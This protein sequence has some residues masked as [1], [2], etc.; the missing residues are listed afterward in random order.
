MLTQTKK[1]S[2]GKLEAKYP[3]V[4]K[5][6]RSRIEKGLLSG[7][8][9]GVREMADEYGVNFMTVNKAIKKLEA[10]GLVDCIP[11]K[12][13]YV[14]RQ[15]SVAAC[16]NSPTL[17]IL[18]IPV[19]HDVVMSAQ[20][21][22]RDHDCPMFLEG[23]SLEQQDVVDTLCQRIDG[24]LLF[25]SNMF[26]IHE[27]LLKMPY[28]RVMG[29]LGDK[30]PGDHVSYDNPMVGRIAADYLIGS[31]CRSMAYIGPF[32]QALFA[33][34]RD[35]F[36]ESIKHAGKKYYEFKTTWKYDFNSTLEQMELLMTLDKLPEAIFAPSDGIMSD[37]CSIL[38]RHGIQ[39]ET[40]IRLIG[41]NNDFTRIS[42]S[43]EIYASIDLHPKQIGTMAARQL[44]KR[45]VDPKLPPYELFIEPELVT[46]ED[47]L[48]QNPNYPS[49]RN[50]RG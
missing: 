9:P 45:I 29:S 33:Q 8:L 27:N 40:D 10:D 5:D 38:Y 12:G 14:K 1:Q 30:I 3:R 22:F 24:L 4:Y 36:A 17:S 11:R 39:P 19:Y 31:G 41:C 26:P 7:A 43:P 25:Y 23:S 2:N 21:Y 35:S 16:I 32:D 15:Y 34:R 48:N 42:T 49:K 28:V 47:I 46:P 6:I 37:V 18:N 13:T 44:M 20:R 50:N